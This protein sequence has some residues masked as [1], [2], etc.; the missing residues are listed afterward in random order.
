[1]HAPQDL[2]V[3][4]L[5][6][7]ANRGAMNMAL[8]AAAAETVEA[9]GPGCVRVYEWAPSTLSLGYAQAPETID[10][11]YCDREG[12]DVTRRPTG[13]GGIYHDSVGDL[14]YSIVLPRSEL[15]GQLME[16][17]AL[18]CEPIIE[19]F[20]RMGVPVRF[21]SEE[22]PAVYDPACYLREL[23][24]AHDL[25]VRGPRGEQKIS[26]NAQHRPR[27]AVIQHGSILFANQPE[28][29]LACFADPAVSVEAFASRVT[30]ISEQVDIDRPTAVGTLEETLGEW[31]DATPGEWTDAELERASDLTSEKFGASHWIERHADQTA[32]G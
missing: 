30:S 20:D 8:D 31:F 13:G 4:H 19:A 25:V 3:R 10:W 9:G 1:M 18:L 5:P 22:R 27:D 7:D 32:E 16:D 17:Y 26:G 29:H 15:S 24:P 6:T 23:H 28:R 12:I 11:H 2:E 14:A 21:A